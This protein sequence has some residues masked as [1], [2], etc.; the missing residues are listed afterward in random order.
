MEAGEKQVLVFD[1]NLCSGCM[2][3]VTVCSTHNTGSSSI[4]KSRVKII[5][6]E[7]H[8]ISRME[9]E[10]ELVFVSINCQQCDEAYCEYICPVG[11]IRRDS[12]TGALTIN[13]E[14]CIGCRMCSM[15]CPFGAI[16]YDSSLKRVFKCELCGGDPWCVK[17]C[18][19]NALQFLPA[20]DINLMKISKIAG[21]E[22]RLLLSQKEL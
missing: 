1:P 19:N 5:R 20:K 13:H 18:T 10:D 22:I 8:A 3:C 15:V 11:A 17:V 14:R 12:E 21:K 6:H 9:E 4:S 7:G 16:S 2:Y